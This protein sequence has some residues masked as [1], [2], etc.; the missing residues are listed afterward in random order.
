MANEHLNRAQE[1]S[2]KVDII[3]SVRE[4]GYIDTFNPRTAA[5]MR[6]SLREVEMLILL[7]ALG[8]AKDAL[9][10]VRA[11]INTTRI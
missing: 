11:A 8:A 1:L 9:R 6:N 7:D 4:S 5:L 3:R 10:E 2:R